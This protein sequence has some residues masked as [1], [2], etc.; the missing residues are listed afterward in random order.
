M[1]DGLVLKS[2]FAQ[3][4]SCEAPYLTFRH[5]LSLGMYSQY[6]SLHTNRTT[7]PTTTQVADTFFELRVVFQQP[8]VPFESACRR[9]AW[10]P[11]DK[12]GGSGLEAM[13]KAVALS[14][15]T[16]VSKEGSTP[17]LRTFRGATGSSPLVPGP[18][19]HQKHLFQKLPKQQQQNVNFQIF[20]NAN[21]KI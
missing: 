18:Q 13:I 9:N 3:D 12:L 15:L 11:N 1:L 10:R 5:K 8:N 6:S 16:W 20:K 4:R 17:S 21:L 19:T 7:F 14:V 2:P